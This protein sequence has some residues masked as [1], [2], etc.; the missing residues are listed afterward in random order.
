M[1][2]SWGRPPAGIFEGNGKWLGIKRIILLN[3]TYTRFYFLTF[4]IFSILLSLYFVSLAHF[5]I[6]M[7]IIKR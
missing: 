5:W 1:M 3:L 7:F 4:L 6:Q 2:D